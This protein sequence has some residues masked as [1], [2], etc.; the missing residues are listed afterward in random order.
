VNN[1]LVAAH[2]ITTSEGLK[3]AAAAG[4][5]PEAALRVVNAATGR[6]AISEIHFPT[7]IM[8]GRF[9]SGFSM[10]LMRKDVRLARELADLIHA[11]LP[12]SEVVARLWAGSVEWLSDTD[13]FTHM[14]ALDGAQINSKKKVAAN[15]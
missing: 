10:G 2:L 9:D 4:V 14:G 1:L 12:L 13:D 11:D 3:L 8:S 15:G 5:S 7:W 6:S